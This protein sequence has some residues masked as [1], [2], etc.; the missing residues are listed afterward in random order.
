MIT[1]AAYTFPYSAQ[2]C[3]QLTYQPKPDFT[4]T[5]SAT[6]KVRKDVPSPMNSPMKMLGMAAGRATRKIR[7]FCPAPKVRATSRYDARVL[8]IPE[9]VSI[10][11]GNQTASAISPTAEE[12]PEGERTIARGTHA[13]AGMGPIT[14]SRGIPQYLAMVLSPSEIGRPTV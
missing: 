8:A 1:R 3:A 5:V 4:P 14:L 9:I 11:T 13:V 7:Y 6:I 10:V 2:P 12:V